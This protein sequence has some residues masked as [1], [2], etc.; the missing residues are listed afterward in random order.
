ML[1]AAHSAW[2]D[3]E[4]TLGSGAD[5]TAVIRWLERLPPVAEASESAEPAS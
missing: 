4:A 2:A 3:A 1:D 5:H